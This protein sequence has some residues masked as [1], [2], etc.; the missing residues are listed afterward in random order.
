MHQRLTQPYITNDPDIKTGT[1]TL[2]EMKSALA[3]SLVSRG[4]ACNRLAKLVLLKAV[5]DSRAGGCKHLSDKSQP[6]AKPAAAWLDAE[7][8]S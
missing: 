6:E 4:Q 5:C 2:T 8:Q 1:A 7:R 3:V